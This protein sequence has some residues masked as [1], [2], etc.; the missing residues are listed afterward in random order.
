[1]THIKYH[2]ANEYHVM[3]QLIEPTPN[4]HKPSRK[5]HRKILIVLLLYNFWLVRKFYFGRALREKSFRDFF[6]DRFLEKI[7]ILKFWQKQ[8]FSQLIS[9]KYLKIC[10]FLEECWTSMRFLLAFTLNDKVN[11]WIN[12]YGRLE[13]VQLEVLFFLF[14]WIQ[15]Y[16]FVQFKNTYNKKW[17]KIKTVLYTKTNTRYNN[18]GKICL[19]NNK[20]T[21]C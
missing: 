1:M 13:D 15:L 11:F 19:R 14:G 18:T 12:R 20:K 3:L 10:A 7:L 6:I 5:F 8:K 9:V 17:Q 21:I 2:C 4:K 16:N